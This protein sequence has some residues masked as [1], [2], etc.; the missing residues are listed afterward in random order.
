MIKYK[1]L[2]KITMIKKHP[3]IEQKQNDLIENVKENIYLFIQ[4][5]WNN[6]K[7][8]NIFVKKSKILDTVLRLEESHSKYCD[9]SYKIK[10]IKV[11]ETKNRNPHI[12]I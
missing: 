10:S 5:C 11:M 9:E 4:L 1:I 2:E 6:N 3:F 7:I 8:L 12:K